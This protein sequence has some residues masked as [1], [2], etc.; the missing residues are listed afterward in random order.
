M[1]SATESGR[2][3]AG[4]TLWNL[5]GTG[6]PVLVALF[7]V[8]LLVRHLG[9]DRFGL[10]TLVWLFVGYFSLF[11]FGLGRAL[12]QIVAAR[13]A[14]KE[15]LVVPVLARSGLHLLIA[16]GAV[17]GVLMVVLS[18]FLVHRILKVP[19]GLQTEAIQSFILLGIAT[20]ITVCTIGLQGLLAA[21]ERF[22]YINTVRI[23]LGLLTFLGAAAVLP[24]T[25]SL[26]VITAVLFVSRIAA[27]LATWRFT[28]RCIP[29]FSFFGSFDGALLRPVLKFAGWMSVSNVVSPLMNYA[30]R[31]IVGAVLS[32][33]AV[34]YYATPYEVA[35]RLLVL[36]TAI[37][38]S[39]FPA[40]SGAISADREAARS[41]FWRSSQSVLF[42]LFPLLLVA[43]AGAHAGLRLWLGADFAAQSSPVMHWLCL[44]ILFNGIAQIAF[45]FVQGGGR[46]DITAMLHLIEAPIYGASLWF[47][48]HRYGI[49]GAAMAWSVRSALDCVMLYFFAEKLSPSSSNKSLAFYLH[50]FFAFA[51]LLVAG[52]SP[53]GWAAAIVG[54]AWVIWVGHREFGHF[55]RRRAV[56]APSSPETLAASAGSS[57]L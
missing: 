48:L 6:A 34:A 52:F 21:Y 35:A 28:L 14:S 49:A 25:N 1:N 41:I 9:T 46:A 37:A 54:F 13:L 18:P 36:P 27:L 57:N 53:Y 40:F 24:F 51:F 26:V 44:G 17:G 15:E 3:L 33:T 43:E 31:L 7:C 23:P 55:L 42:L 56:L 30:D 22:D 45:S 38:A 12:T 5:A 4:N 29:S 2:R 8:P 19:V 20:P 10:L 16:T 39:A 50:T 11:D 47:L 32:V